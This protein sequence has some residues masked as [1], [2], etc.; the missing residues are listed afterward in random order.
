MSAKP[1]IRE[2][3]QWRAKL[4]FG[5]VF[6]IGTLIAAQIFVVQNFQKKKWMDKVAKVQRKPM[7]IKATRGN[8]YAADG[9]SLL[10]TS[11]PRY[12][13]GIDVTRA[14][15]KYLNAQLDSLT[16]LMAGFF[17]D[18]TA[19]QYR[20]L[21]MN[22]RKG[23]KVHFVVLGDRLVDF[24]EM[25]KIKKFPFFREGPMKGGGKFEQLNR[26]VMPFDDMALRS[27]GKLDRDT[28]TKGDFGI[29]FSFN[30]YL[31]GRDGVGLFQRLAGG[32]WK[33]VEDSPDVR[34]ESG[35]D[36]VTTIDINFQDIVESS[37][38]NQVMSTNAKYGSAIVMEVATGQIKA[39]TNLSRRNKNDQTYYTEDFN[40]AVKGGTDP[41]ST[42]KLATM[43]AILEKSHLN[44]NDFGATC[45]GSVRHNNIEL[46]CDAKHGSQT[47]QQIFE[48]SCNVG[49]YNL[50]KQHFG[51]SRANNFVAYLSRLKLDKPVGFQLR[52]E[53]DPIIKDSKSSTFSSTTIPWMAIGYE[54]R[55]TPLQMLT[56]Y[57]AIANGGKWVQP[58]IV[59]E[60][61]EADRVLER[62]EGKKDGQIC[63]DRT[64]K[65]VHQMMKGVVENG[66]AQN[67]NTGFCKVAGKTGTSQKRENG[68]VKGQYYTAFIGFF[69]ADN[70]RYSCAVIIDEPQ[71]INVHARDVAA[72]VFRTI[73]DKIFAYDVA[74]HPPKNKNA[75]VQNITSHEQS[76]YSE[77]FRAVSE[78]L[79]LENVPASAGWTKAVKNGSNITWRKINENED[80]PNVSGMT[81]RDAIYLLE[82]KGFKVQYT[83][84]GKVADYAIIQPK[85]VSLILQ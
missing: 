50:V 37:L 17:Q 23:G 3:I 10:A 46:T 16:H 73:A 4:T 29:E 44:P 62:F 64:I 66:T 65:I 80:I 49:I 76:G 30:N 83:G 26:R 38:R 22:A 59:K 8:I 85:V 67:I 39:I 2:E 79:G 7:K 60:I 28:Q 63:S 11:V 42:F 15:P 31:A 51:F 36:V 41:G 6:V 54:S 5:L 71:G 18:R 21:I 81:L 74:M 84:L 1:S 70:P 43:V 68:Y 58:Y 32:V 34:P 9:S 75:N 55:L 47:V 61:R 82:N 27:I 45:D 48:N 78:T 35:Q 56:F 40:Y 77:D 33:P 12:R 20:E 72:P 19:R 53:T 13:V 25:E 14:K 24:T 57:N 52:G 69:P